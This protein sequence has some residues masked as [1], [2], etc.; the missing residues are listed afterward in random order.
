VL[1][2]GPHSLVEMKDELYVLVA[3][4]R[5]A[6]F[7]NAYQTVREVLLG[8]DSPVAVNSEGSGSGSPGTSY[9]EFGE[10]HPAS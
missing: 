1:G 3:T 8:L 4:M 7:D 10:H 6:G 2:E 5:I 9:D